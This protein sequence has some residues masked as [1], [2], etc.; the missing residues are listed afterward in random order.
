MFRIA[1][2][3]FLMTETN[4]NT[5]LSDTEKYKA[6]LLA[7]EPHVLTVLKES[8]TEYSKQLLSL[9]S[10]IMALSVA[11]LKNLVTVK[12]AIWF[13]LLYT[14]WGLF[15][16][17]I[18]FTLVS[19]RVSLCAH[20]LL[21]ADI[22]KAKEDKQAVGETWRDPLIKA[23]GVLTTLCFVGG[24]GCLLVFVISNVHKERAMPDAENS[25]ISQLYDPKTD[26]RLNW[27]LPV[28][29]TPVPIKQPPPPPP[30]PD[31]PKR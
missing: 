8:Q 12:S 29:P 21:F 19:I 22:Q 4:L 15:A 9:S 6:Q 7:L 28:R 24:I 1:F 30:P 3:R 20:M 23:L 10:A 16:G 11:F 25:L 27:V 31:K 2:R 13:P 26:D 14:A 18:F 5:V 17:T